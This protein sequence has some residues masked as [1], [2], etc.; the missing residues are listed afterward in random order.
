VAM[1]T[2]NG[3]RSLGVKTGRIA[4]GYLADFSMIDLEAASLA[5]W[6][7]DTLLESIIFGADNEVVVGTCVGGK[8]HP[9]L[10]DGGIH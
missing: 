9:S 5:G 7:A 6:S 2:I 4:P 3:A 1:A 8:W 10:S